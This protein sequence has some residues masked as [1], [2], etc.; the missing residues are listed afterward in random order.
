MLLSRLG[1]SDKNQ[2]FEVS[3]T[4]LINAKEVASELQ[5]PSRKL[6]PQHRRYPAC[7]ASYENRYPELLRPVE[8]SGQRHR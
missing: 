1:Q 2:S 5:L 3:Y 7:I 4:E 8:H 6:L